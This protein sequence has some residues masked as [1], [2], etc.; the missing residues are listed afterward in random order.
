MRIGIL[1]VKTLPAFA[2]A[3]RVVEQTLLHASGQHRYAVY[4]IRGA[5]PPT[6]APPWIERI[7][8]PALKGKHARAFSFFLLSALHCVFRL[9]PDVAHAHNS[10]F[11]VFTLLLRLRPGMRR[12]GTLH[13]DPY[14]RAK[15]GRMA[16]L[17]LRLS[18]WFFVHNVHALTSVD[19]GKL[20]ALPPAVARRAHYIPNGMDRPALKPRHPSP[21]MA[22]WGL[23]TDGFVLFACGRLDP[24]KGLHHLL[25]AWRD[26]PDH[27]LELVVIGDF[28]HDAG[29]AADIR[30]TAAALSHV[31]LHEALLPKDELLDLLRNARSLV[32]PSEVEAMS[33]MLLEAVACRCPV[34]CSDIR[35][36][37]AVVGADYPYRFRSGDAD[38]LRT[39]LLRLMADPH[40]RDVADR[41]YSA[42]SERFAWPKIAGSYEALYG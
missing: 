27:D 30:R 14:K 22:A 25:K 12:I 20:E 37:L 23:P 15:W 5:E 32:F 36:N 39:V 2:G 35:E 41:L 10:D 19:E 34:V 28:S 24:T 31:R 7:E 13:G 9:R 1:G 26:L 40:A 4:V 8:L 6:D 11:G 16:R 38:D 21:R 42:C 3:D 17:Y 18:E 29:Y 33:M